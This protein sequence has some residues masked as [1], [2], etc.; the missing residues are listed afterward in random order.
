LYTPTPESS[1][2][3]VNQIRSC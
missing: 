2:R 1:V 3:P